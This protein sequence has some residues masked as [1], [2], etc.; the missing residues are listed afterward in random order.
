MADKTNAPNI[1][2]AGLAT[3]G[4]AGPVTRRRR[5]FGVQHLPLVGLG[6]FAAALRGRDVKQHQQPDAARPRRDKDWNK[7]AER[8]KKLLA[9]PR[10][11]PLR[12]RNR[13]LARKCRAAGVRN[14]AGLYAK[15]HAS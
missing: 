4:G 1:T 6:S 13:I 2:V 5:L 11:L 3:A 15:R 9:T 7:R 10:S 8:Q 14:A 12:E